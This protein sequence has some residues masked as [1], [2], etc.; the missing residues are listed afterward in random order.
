MKFSRSSRLGFSGRCSQGWP[1]QNICLHPLISNQLANLP[2]G[3]TFC[4]L[5]GR[6]NSQEVSLFATSDLR[7]VGL[8]SSLNIEPSLACHSNS[9]F[10]QSIY[11][12]VQA[13]GRVCKKW[14]HVSHDCHKVLTP[15]CHKGGWSLCCCCRQKCCTGWGETLLP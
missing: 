8:F 14:A 12:Y 10:L 15:S 6:S 4:L 2:V 11:I 3:L 1:Q 7:M 5:P 9:G 13:H